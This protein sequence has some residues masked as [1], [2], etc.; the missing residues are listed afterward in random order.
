MTS[1]EMLDELRK[2]WDVRIGTAF[3]NEPGDIDQPM[4]ELWML[5]ASKQATDEFA[6]RYVEPKLETAIARAWAGE[7]GDG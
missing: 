2:S 3:A 1:I 7:P 5:N 6:T 4:V